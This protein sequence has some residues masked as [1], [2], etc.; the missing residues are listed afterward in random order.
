MYD[1][2]SIEM[3]REYILGHLL[4]TVD[5]E[6]RKVGQTSAE[7]RN[8]YVFPAAIQD[9]R[10]GTFSRDASILE[11]KRKNNITVDQASIVDRIEDGYD[12]LDMYQGATKELLEMEIERRNRMV[13]DTQI[14]GLGEDEQIQSARKA[15][16]FWYKEREVLE[17]VDFV[18]Q[19]YNHIQ[20]ANVDR[21]DLDPAYY[22]IRLSSYDQIR[23]VIPLDRTI[24]YDEEN[25]DQI[26]DREMVAAVAD[27]LVRMCNY[28][29]KIREKLKL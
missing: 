3:F 21:Y 29:C 7:T 15:R 5:V 1:S 19:T 10:N 8:I 11:F 14:P 16:Y 13:L 28:I 20:D 25:I 26:P 18:N 6:I 12:R 4:Q 23:S 17:Y 9:R 22:E 24:P 27:R 2:A